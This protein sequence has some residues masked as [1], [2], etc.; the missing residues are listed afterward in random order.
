VWIDELQLGTI[1]DEKGNFRLDSVCKGKYSVKVSFIGHQEEIKILEVD[2][3]VNVT[4]RMKGTDILLQ[5][6]E[7]HGHRDA[8]IT[9]NTISSLK[10][11]ALDESRG[12][13]LGNTLQ[14]IAGVSTYSTGAS[15]SKPVI[16]GMHSNRI[17]ILNNGIRQEG[18]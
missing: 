7:I 2:R 4:F 14:R 12:E 3:N 10:G 15:I 11:E 5:G 8:V 9:T 16:H 17:M 6:V 1:S 13:S 18:Q